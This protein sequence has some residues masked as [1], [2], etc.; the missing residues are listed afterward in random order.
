MG[1]CL[2]FWFDF[3]MTTGDGCVDGVCIDGE[4]KLYGVVFVDIGDHIGG[5]YFCFLSVIGNCIYMVANIWFDGYGSSGIWFYFLGGR[6]DG[7]VT[8][9]YGS[10]Y[11]VDEGKSGR[12][13]CETENKQKYCCNENKFLKH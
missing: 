1:D 11:G 12:N 9:G 10:G 5:C 2:G 13:F 6:G 8:T 4:G 7:A 3:A